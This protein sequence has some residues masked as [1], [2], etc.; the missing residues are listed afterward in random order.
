VNVG[1]GL[2]NPVPGTAGRTLIAWAR[3]AEERGFSTLATIDRIA[4]PSYESLTALAAAAAVTRDIGLLTNILLGP[5]RNA[6]LLAKE[7]ASVDQLSNG[8]LTL[9]LAVGTRK[10]DFD[11][12]GVEFGARGR[13]WDA[14]LETIHRAWRGELVAGA[15]K[16]IG[17]APVRDGRVPVLIGGTSDAAMRRVVTW[18]AGWTLGGAP[19]ERGGPFAQ[20]VRAAW[21]QAGREGAPRIVGLSYF[22][23]GSDAKDRARGYLTDY[24]GPVGDRIAAFIPTSPEAIRDVISAFA[25]FGFD[26][27]I[28]DPTI[29]ELEQLDGVADAALG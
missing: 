7:S 19:P 1:V 18:G 26:E 25:S 2:P 16:P 21:K 20:Q 27:V 13:K 24:Y 4:Y 15:D 22:A 12:V 17:P 3:R 9:G 5:T 23:L 14:D 28:L 6:V 11:A 8:R 29:A 10:D